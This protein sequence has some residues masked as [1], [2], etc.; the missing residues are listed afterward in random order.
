M[1]TRSA[2]I[3]ALMKGRPGRDGLKGVSVYVAWRGERIERSTGIAVDEV[4]WD[5]VNQ[6]VVG[7]SGSDRLNAKLDNM[8]SIL[9]GR[10]DQLEAE[11]R[12]YRVKDIM[13][14]LDELSSSSSPVV[15]SDGEKG[16][17]FS[18]LMEGFMASRRLSWSSRNAYERFGR[19][20]VQYFGGN[21]RVNAD[22]DYSGFLNHLSSI[23]AETSAFQLWRCLTAVI[24]YGIERGWIEGVSPLST[25]RVKK[26]G[27]IKPKVALDEVMIGKLVKWLSRSCVYDDA[28]GSFLRGDG[29][30]NPNKK[31]CAVGLY[32]MMYY[33]SGLSPIDLAQLKSEQLMMDGGARCF[34]LDRQKTGVSAY[35]V[36]SDS[37]KFYVSLFNLYLNTSSSRLGY[38]FPFL[39]WSRAC[40]T[41]YKK[42]FS[43]QQIY[44]RV[45][46]VLYRL[47]QRLRQVVTELNAE[48]ACIPSSLTF[49]SARHSFAT[50]FISR[51]SN[52]NALCSAMGRSPNTIATYISDLQRADVMKAELNKLF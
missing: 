41:K 25:L 14:A 50:R 21:A 32:L 38:I 29:L 26:P 6:R 8:L 52:I 18:D 9:R 2:V 10:R 48:G 15:N 39:Y 20:F 42:G 49:Y 27:K 3:G 19:A 11:G 45:R 51:S 13:D 37:N 28:R 31:E 30:L 47:N 16:I 24:N 35:I 23:Y 43:E 40:I 17:I 5:R 33:L 7:L 4:N 34:N 44:T 22:L 12:G 36:L 1:R 46:F